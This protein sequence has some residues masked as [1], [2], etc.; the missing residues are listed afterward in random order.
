[1]KIEFDNEKDKELFTVLL[2]SFISM[3]EMEPDEQDFINRVY[4]EIRK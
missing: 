4:E 1:M 3:S 2:D